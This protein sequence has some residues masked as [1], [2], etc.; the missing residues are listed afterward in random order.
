M[1]MITGEESG[2][3]LTAAFKQEIDA[4]A[5]APISERPLPLDL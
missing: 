5:R 3:I 1:A 4:W 2:L